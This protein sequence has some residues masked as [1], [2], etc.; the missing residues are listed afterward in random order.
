MRLSGEEIAFFKQYGYLIKRRAMSQ[1]QCSAARKRMWECDPPTHLL[2][3][4]DGAGCNVVG[5]V[6][7]SEQ[8][9]DSSNFKY[10]YRWQVRS[11]GAER[12]VLGAIANPSIVAMAQQLVGEDVVVPQWDGGP[13]GK[14]WNGLA[15]EGA[16]G[17]AQDHGPPPATGATIGS[18]R[19]S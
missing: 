9:G 4:R 6:S 19:A 15:E 5:P 17:A 18:R 14:D 13:T 10:G 11:I 3:I 12:A 16:R 8:S 2:P 7:K 1:E